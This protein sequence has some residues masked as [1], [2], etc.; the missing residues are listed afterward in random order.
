[1]AFDKR[2]MP[3]DLNKIDQSIILIGK[4]LDDDMLRLA[5]GLVNLAK[6][7]CD[8]FCCLERNAGK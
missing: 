3:K 4:R 7:S 2:D 8:D 5:K 6:R 1:M